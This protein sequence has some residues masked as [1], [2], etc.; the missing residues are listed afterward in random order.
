MYAKA[1]LALLVLWPIVP[2][3]SPLELPQQGRLLIYIEGRQ[4]GYENFQF[5]MDDGGLELSTESN[6]VISE[7]GAPSRLSFE[8]KLLLDPETLAAKSYLYRFKGEGRDSYQVDFEAGR[9]TRRLLRGGRLDIKTSQLEH[10]PLLLDYNIYSH[11][12]LLLH[13]Y[14]LKKGGE[15]GFY[16]YLPLL[17][18]EMPVS[19]S[20]VGEVPISSGG[21]AIK[22]RA[23]KVDF[24][25]IYSADILASP[26]NGILKITIPRGAIEVVGE[27]VGR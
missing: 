17:G 15:Q 23:F 5:R 18:E 8:S 6:M 4:S 3:L 16:S 26:D 19:V 24:A 21:A 7:S 9:A 10:Q 22:A 2:R 1:A 25:G 11:F 13:R 12:M 14:D 20:F 27:V